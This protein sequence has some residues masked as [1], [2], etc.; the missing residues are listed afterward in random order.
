ML[1]VKIPMIITMVFGVFMILKFFLTV[2]WIH[3]IASELE[4]WCLVVFS[5]ALVLGTANILRLNL[6]SV[7]R[8]EK[9][10]CGIGK[11]D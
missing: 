10:D 2:P 1:K 3:S 6:K 11:L 7:M 4:Q 8:K 5:M 9:D